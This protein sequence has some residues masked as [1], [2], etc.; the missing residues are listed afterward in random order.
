M[1]FR[2]LGPLEVWRD[3][4]KVPLGKPRER[5]VLALLLLSANEVV[6][7]EELID[8]LWGDEPPPTAK[9]ALHNAVSALRGVLGE[10]AIETVGAGYRMQVQPHELDA[11][12]FETLVAD[13]RGAAAEVRRERLREALAEWRGHPLSEYAFAEA[14]IVRLEELHLV[15]LEERIDAELEL[16]RAAELVPE[17]QALAASYPLRER[18]WAQLMLSLY[19]A[20]RPAEALAT[21]RRAHAAFVDELGLE[22]GATL[23]ELQRAILLQDKAL[24]ELHRGPDLIERAANFLPTS[25]AG[26]AE[27]LYD[28]GLALWRTGER[29]RAKSALL[30][31]ERRADVIRHRTL[32]HRARALRASHAVQAGEITAHQFERIAAEAVEAS[33]DES[34]LVALADALLAHGHALRE[35]GRADTAVACHR[36][37]IELTLEIGDRWRE[38]LARSMLGLVL[39]LGT[40]SVADAVA[41][42]K[43]HLEVLEWGSPGPVGLWMALGM[44]H[45]QA[46]RADEGQQYL[47]RADES[48]RTVGAA[49]TLSTVELFRAW[50]ASIAGDRVQAI[51]HARTALELLD[52]L[53]DVGSR[54][55]VAALLARL[56]A[57][58]GRVDDADLL[59]ATAR[60]M[61]EQNGGLFL[62]VSVRRAEA[63]VS[64]AR[65]DDNGVADALRDGCARAA[66]S[67]FLTLYAETLEDAGELER[68]LATFERK[69][70][71][72]SAARVRWKTT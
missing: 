67:D 7:R 33:R 56:E 71:I 49:S 23:R 50:T 36:E 15:A 8:R 64:R 41:E 47:D 69:G 1:D 58:A 45:T 16:G 43:H 13:A 9:A 66:A 12:R 40:T 32:A 4:I 44:L 46:G 54:C 10:E 52:S 2:V 11:L 37:G 60:S 3:G 20:G 31:C 65:G 21:Y 38:G 17:L 29:A 62:H 68:A 25:E 55:D 48:L 26:R 42:C 34:D 72:V 70:D 61:L 22:P 6:P 24:F 53:A 57:Q 51:A 18:F 19:R 30:E 14:E 35:V 28:Y 5:A 59:L 63:A 39:M 27:A